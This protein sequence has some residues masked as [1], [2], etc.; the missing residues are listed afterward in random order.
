MLSNSP[1]EQRPQWKGD[2]PRLKY[3]PLPVFIIGM[4]MAALM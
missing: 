1:E 4:N 2:L 3:L